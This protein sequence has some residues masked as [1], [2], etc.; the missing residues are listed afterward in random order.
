MQYEALRHREAYNATDYL[1]PIVAVL[2]RTFSR[3]PLPYDARRSHE[4]YLKKP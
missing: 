1:A 4:K 3:N 2:F